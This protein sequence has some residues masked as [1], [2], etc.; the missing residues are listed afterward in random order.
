MCSLRNQ[1]EFGKF[2]RS[3]RAERGLTLRELKKRTGISIGYLSKLERA[4]KPPAGS[5]KI[6]QLAKA[7]EV[8]AEYLKSIAFRSS[9]EISARHSDI[10]WCKSVRLKEKAGTVERKGILA[11]ISALRAVLQSSRDPSILQNCSMALGML[12]KCNVPSD[13]PDSF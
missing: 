3:I 13:V 12:E 4:H 7:L 5:D 9:S 8:D 2:L 1:S 11:A 10:E 6:E